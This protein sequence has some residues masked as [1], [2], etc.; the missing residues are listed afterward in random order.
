MARL[1]RIIAFQALVLMVLVA[2]N[3]PAQ[4]LI[5]PVVGG[6]LGWVT[7]KEKDNR[8]LYSSKPGLTFHAGA[9]LS[10]RMSKTVFLHTSV[11]YN[12]KNKDLS[13]R[14]DPKFSNEAKL[15]F[16][17]IPI[18]FTKEVKM[19]V[20]KNKYYNLYFGAGPTVS[21]WLGGRGTLTS[22]ELNENTINPPNYDLPYTIAFNDNP[23]EIPLGTMNVADANRIQLGL[24]FTAGVVFEPMRRQRFMLTLRYELG[25]SYFSQD[26]D[27]DYGLAGVL[28]YEDDMQSRPQSLGASLFYFVDLKT[29]E[30]KKGKSTSKIKVKR[31]R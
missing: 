17:D 30:R 13:G 3:V 8:R 22:S 2:H 9:S 21:Y 14:L 15:N 25:H 5:G 11:L 4:V 29:E 1:T 16:I 12:Q 26:T 7:F 6:Q 24:N 18:S 27:G 10:F 19:Q 23:Q 20:G 31:R 28:F